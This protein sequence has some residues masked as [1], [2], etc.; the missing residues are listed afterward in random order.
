MSMLI[1][2]FM[3]LFC[4]VLALLLS[5]SYVSAEIATKVI[6][7]DTLVL[8]GVVKVRLYGIDCPED[9]QE[10]GDEATEAACSL[11]HGQNVG[12]E[13]L[14][15]DRYGRMIGIIFLPDGTTLQESLLAQGLA[16][17]APRYCKRA[18]CRAWKVLEANA[19]REKRGLWR[20][21]HPSP[22]WEWR[23]RKRDKE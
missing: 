3:R 20:H 6:D 2:I 14:G 1:D 21:P 19:R 15:T 10:S 11:L 9:G 5:P 7:G 18:E 12:L 4:F 22:P 13:A 8:D 17:V 23:K 16:W